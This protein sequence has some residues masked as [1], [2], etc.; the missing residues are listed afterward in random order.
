[1]F[2]STPGL[3]FLHFLIREPQKNSYIIA[4][5]IHVSPNKLEQTDPKLPMVYLVLLIMLYIMI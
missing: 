1:M 2:K 4:I 3:G 5:Y